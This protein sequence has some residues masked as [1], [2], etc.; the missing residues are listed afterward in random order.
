[1]VLLGGNYF[2]Y[3]LNV[4]GCMFIKLIPLK[5]FKSTSFHVTT[6]EATSRFS[7]PAVWIDVD[8]TYAV[9]RSIPT[10]CSSQ[11]LRTSLADVKSF[12]QTRHAI[13]DIINLG[14][15]A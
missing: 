7:T 1:M 10:G 14:G 5:S 15:K 13:G 11:C 3:L 12:W 9:R 6:E 4:T 2:K 8:N